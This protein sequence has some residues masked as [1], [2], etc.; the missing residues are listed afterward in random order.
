MGQER[1][2]LPTGQSSGAARSEMLKRGQEC[3]TQKQARAEFR[4]LP[5][6]GFAFFLFRKRL[7]VPINQGM[8]AFKFFLMRQKFRL[9]LGL[10]RVTQIV[11]V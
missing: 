9:K 7:E 6:R 5:L 2:S 4:G 3:P 1:Q 11:K 10:F 8:C